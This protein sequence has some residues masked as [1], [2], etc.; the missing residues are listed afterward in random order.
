MLEYA[1]NEGRCLPITDREDE[2]PSKHNVVLF[3][4]TYHYYQMELTRL[5]EAERYK[6]AAE[7]LEFL[8]QFEGENEEILLEWKALY[9]W[10]LFVFPETQ[11]L[12]E[13]QDNLI[14]NEESN[15][16]LEV[17]SEEE[18]LHAHT[19]KKQQM[20]EHY[21]NR[22]L[23]SL[24]GSRM[25]E[26]SWLVMEQLVNVDDEQL[27]DDIIHMLEIE[28]LHPLIQYGLLQTLNRRQ[29]TGKV[30]MMRENEQITVRIEDT[31]M[32]YASFP[33]ILQM[34]VEQVH[35]A[36]AVREPSLAYF[37][38]EIWQQFL[39]AIYG[40]SLYDQLEKSQP[41]DLNV[42]AAALHWLVAGFLHLEEQEAEVMRTYSVQPEQRICYEQ[43]LRE[44][45][46]S[47][48][49]G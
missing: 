40:S 10:L 30:L 14:H 11:Q 1:P 21:V 48:R 39:K 35:D 8:L 43:A 46:K 34:P 44:L 13:G 5:L 6:E 15:T 19:V 26:R 23:H 17:E 2:F 29:A 9:E 49:N 16:E 37:A 24:K 25:D 4:K 36:V 12:H 31:P 18:L 45:S 47:R 42:W 32:D 33:S 27:D 22:L 28:P 3:P 38:Q 20:D 7:L 41:A